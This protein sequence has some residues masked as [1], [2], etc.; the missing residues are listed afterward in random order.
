MSLLPSLIKKQAQAFSGIEAN[1]A[2]AGLTRVHASD[3][4]DAD[5]YVV[6]GLCVGH[7]SLFIR[8][9]SRW[10]DAPVTVL[11]VK[12]RVTGNNPCAALYLAD[13]YFKNTFG[14]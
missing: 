7:D 3:L 6:L 2:G 12:D 11:A 5:L 10:S 4:T 9:A 1:L 8:Y 14:D 13:G